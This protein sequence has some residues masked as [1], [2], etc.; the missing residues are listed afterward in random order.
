MSAAAVALSTTKHRLDGS[1]LLQQLMPLAASL[2][3]AVGAGDLSRMHSVLTLLQSVPM[4]GQLLFA[5]QV[6]LPVRS[7]LQQQVQLQAQHRGQKQ[8][9]QLLDDVVA[10]AKQ[11]LRRWRGLLKAEVDACD[12]YRMAR[13]QQVGGWGGG[14][15][16]LLDRVFT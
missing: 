3:V 6:A 7:I 11:L 9:L 16:P 10:A 2:G 12:E 4:T 5:S 15:N 14:R 1:L 8:E 13:A